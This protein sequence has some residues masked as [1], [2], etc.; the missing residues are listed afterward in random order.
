MLTGKPNQKAQQAEEYL[1]RDD[2]YLGTPGYWRGKLAETLGLPSGSEV[3]KVE[4]SNLLRGYDQNE[5]PL[6]QN[7]G[8]DH[9]NAG[10]DLTFHA[11]KSLS[12]LA[13]SDSRLKTAFH[14][15]LH[16]TLD[17][18]EE[19]FIQT[20]HKKEGDISYE[21]TKN[22]AFAI[23]EHKTSRELDPLLHAHCLMI[24]MTLDSRGKFMSIH[25]TIFENYKLHLGQFFRN[26]LALE[27]QKLGYQI[28]FPEQKELRGKGF[29]EIQGVTRDVIDDFS[30]RSKQ[31]K[32]KVEYLRNL[33]FRDIQKG[34][35]KLDEWAADRIDWQITEKVM[36]A[37][38]EK[39]AAKR[40]A[41]RL[42]PNQG[43]PENYRDLLAQE[44]EILKESREERAKLKKLTAKQVD[45]LIA[46]NRSRPDYPEQV[47][48]EAEALKTSDEKVYAKWGDVE[49]AALATTKS[50]VSKRE[51]ENEYVVEQINST[52]KKRGLALDGLVTLAQAE[53]PTKLNDTT[54]KDAI[55]AV[56]ADAT[57][58]EVAFTKEDITRD[59]MRLTLGRYSA[60]E[61]VAAFDRLV[62]VGE[63]SPLRTVVKGRLPEEVN[64]Y[65]TP[66]L[67]AMEAENINLCRNSKTN[68][69]IDPQISESVIAEEDQRLIEE[70]GFGFTPGQKKGIRQIVETGRQFS[71][72]QGD[73]G[74][75]KS[76]SIFYARQLLEKHGYNVRGLAPTGKAADELHSAAEIEATA[77]LHKML[78]DPKKYNLE[79]GNEAFIVDESSMADSRIINK[80]LKVAK[81]YDAKVVFVG[82]RKQFAAV[83][84]GRFFLDLQDKTDV[85]ITVMEDV[86]RQKTEQT[87]GIVKAISS[88]K[89]DAAFSLLSG[90]TPVNFDQSRIENYRP[91]QMLSLDRSIPEIPVKRPEGG[92]VRVTAVGE[93]SLTISYKS[94][95][96]D[97]EVE[98]NPKTAH[99]AYTVYTPNDT[100]KNCIQIIQ[101]S[102]A[103]L[104]AVAD[105]YINCNNTGKNALVITAT[106]NERR[107]LNTLIREILV[108][109]DKVEEVGEFSL[110]EPTN[111]GKFIFA[112]S[113]QPGQFIK[114]LPQLKVDNKYEYGEIIGIDQNQ[115]RLK[116]RNVKTNEKFTVD[117]SKYAAKTFS[118][119]NQAPTKLGIN[120]RITFLKNVWLP[121]SAG[122]PVNVCNG[123]LATITALDKQGN[124]TVK[125]ESGKDVRFNLNEYNQLTT[126][127]ALSSHKSQ[128]M[129]IDKLIW[130][131][132]TETEISTNSFY[133]AITRCKYD[134]A[135]YTDDIDRLQ[136]KA[137]QEQEKY[138]TLEDDY[139]QDDPVQERQQEINAEKV[140]DKEQ[141]SNKGLEQNKAVESE[142]AAVRDKVVDRAS[143][144]IPNPLDYI[145]N[146]KAITPDMVDEISKIDKMLSDR[147][148]VL[149][150][151]TYDIMIKK[152]FNDAKTNV[153]KEDAGKKAAMFVL[154]IEHEMNRKGIKVIV[155]EKPVKWAVNNHEKLEKQIAVSKEHKVQIGQ[156]MGIR[157][158]GTEGPL[159]VMYRQLDEFNERNPENST[160]K[161]S[162]SQYKSVEG[163]D[164]EG[165]NQR[166]DCMVSVDFKEDVRM[167]HLKFTPDGKCLGWMKD[168]NGGAVFGNTDVQK[169]IPAVKDGKPL[170]AQLRDVNGSAIFNKDNSPMMINKN[171]PAVY[172]GTQ[173]VATELVV[174]N[175]TVRVLVNEKIIYNAQSQLENDPN[176]G[177]GFDR[178]GRRVAASALR[179][180]F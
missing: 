93:N 144:G 119:F 69:Q 152:P 105:D 139:D 160:Y 112:D 47:G 147:N 17:Y 145:V 51:V 110:L 37:E 87:K 58:R 82:D 116:I 155:N 97:I 83:G 81:D 171:I 140:V 55:M 143:S 50:R 164:A 28:Y 157:P 78:Q 133:V 90:F 42:A 169:S 128:G 34:D 6:V 21:K 137:K 173:G 84:A 95:G 24:N 122:Q 177:R 178:G 40:V 96:R 74:T 44:I 148:I 32:K 111:V 138:S 114:G 126:A 101:D 175:S 20:R 115:N 19:E 5:I 132:N 165:K 136:K 109:Q 130:Q 39:E 98:I 54:P 156:V 79:K 14:T 85:D 176:Y 31:V 108:A 146:S 2:Y 86:I 15:A 72:I 65:T 168:K 8:Q 9:R 91:G 66:E 12:L 172:I 161:Y 103:R 68:I 159:A 70:N 123:Q 60:T 57:Q 26:Q 16:N 153:E 120:E 134:V 135:V 142:I 43:F 129:T 151:K 30:K 27:V 53:P 45:E 167:Q 23:F 113:F 124:I 102:Q 3:K 38:R 106:N 166:F 56:V 49:L 131:A 52:L 99:T 77:T 100:Y 73:A 18:A 179:T 25:N 36:D 13:F 7:A 61:V 35:G 64:I 149:P 141:E 48:Q 29:F 174:R 158:D 59:A 46:M 88:K 180:D 80:L 150:E 170:Q 41:L 94:Y 1:G 4:F 75:G 89:V 117:P 121:D 22:A 125:M 127:Y 107:E 162:V 92:A 104:Q 163:K 11:P 118:V 154:A 63:L 33:S 10:S 67:K 71:V 62:K 76:F